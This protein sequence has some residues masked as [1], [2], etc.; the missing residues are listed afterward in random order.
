MKILAYGDPRLKRVAEPVD[1]ENTTLKQ[2]TEIVRKMANALRA[3]GHGMQLGLAAPQIGINKRVVIAKGNVLFNPEFVPTKAP[4]DTFFEGCYSVPGKVFKVPRA[5]Y[6]WLK[7]QNID[8]K[9]CEQKLK[10]INAV[11]VQHEIDHLNGICCCDVGVEH[12][13]L[14]E[15]GRTPQSN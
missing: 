3:T 8:G 5:P 2:R 11:V 12:K 7:W 13:E 1:F 6:G 15:P 9:H 14:G 4:K 10:D